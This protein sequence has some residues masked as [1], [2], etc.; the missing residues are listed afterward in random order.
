MSRTGRVWT[1]S[2]AAL[3]GANNPVFLLFADGAFIDSEARYYEPRMKQP[4]LMRVMANAGSLLPSLGRSSIGELELVNA[5]GGLNHLADYAMDGRECVIT[6]WDNGAPSE[7]F[8]GTVSS[9][10]ERGNSFT[11]TLRPG[12]QSLDKPYPM[13]LYLGDN[14]LPAGVEGVDDIAGRVKPVVFGRV[15]NAAPA[16]VNTALLIYQVSELPCVVSKV[17]DRGVELTR[18]AD[19]ADLAEMQAAAPEAGEVR[20]F[21]GWFRLGSSPSGTITCDAS[22][23]D[24]SGRKAGSL[25]SAL[26]VGAG[27]AL[28]PTCA[29]DLDGISGECGF[30]LAEETAVNQLLDRFAEA[31]GAY[32]YFADGLVKFGLLQAP[33]GGGLALQDWQL[34]SI[35]RSA[36]AAGNN[37][38]PVSKVTIPHSEVSAIQTDLAGSASDELK[39]RLAERWRQQHSESLATTERHPLAEPLAVQLGVSFEATKVKVVSDRLLSLLSVRRDLVTV[40]VQID[41]LT[42]ITIGDQF[43]V[44]TRRLGYNQG[45]D[46]ICLGY[47]I[48]AKKNRVTLELFG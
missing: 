16:F 43:T 33:S 46:M 27:S 15:D 48:N 40:D 19:Y 9:V 3:D 13:A 20:C 25:L 36:L 41:A 44:A 1:A 24:T 42:P 10:R 39:A 14:I 45:R 32:W 28:C 17:R 7:Y 37:G 30:F 2:I 8:S 26:L 23:G 47:E 22:A 18:G 4:A 34:L 11:F 5:D 12:S 21:Q 38:L 35:E 6:L 31:L 29:T